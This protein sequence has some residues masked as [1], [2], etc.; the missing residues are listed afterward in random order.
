MFRYSFSDWTKEE[1]TIDSG[2]SIL[3]ITM[4]DDNKILVG[5]QNGKLHVIDETNYTE[6]RSFSSP[7]RVIIANYGVDGELYVISTFS[8]SSK[9]RLFDIDTDG[10]SVTDSLDDFP[11]DSTQ[12]ADS[13]GDGYGDNINGNSPDYFPR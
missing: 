4:T 9:I 7:G 3:S 11:E 2:Q 1:L 5:T 8:S 6:L 10:D 13:D 12:S